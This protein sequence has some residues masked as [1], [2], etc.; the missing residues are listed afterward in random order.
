[1]AAAIDCGDSGGRQT[2]SALDICEFDSIVR[3]TVVSAIVLHTVAVKG[4]KM[5]FVI[6]RVDEVRAA[7]VEAGIKRVGRDLLP[8][9]TEVGI[10]CQIESIQPAVDA[11]VIAHRTGRISPS[12]SR[13]RLPVTWKVPAGMRTGRALHSAATWG[14]SGGTVRYVPPACAL[15][16]FEMA[17]LSYHVEE[18]DVAI[19]QMCVS[20]GHD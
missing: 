9:Q 10:Y 8:L 4:S 20:S 19:L 12:S 6:V 7:F 11:S 18:G 1:M 3:V 2:C 17:P 16:H 15:E 13:R 5:S 14:N